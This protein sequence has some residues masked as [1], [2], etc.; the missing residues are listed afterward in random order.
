MFHCLFN[1]ITYEKPSQ[2]QLCDSVMYQDIFSDT[3]ETY[4]NNEF[5]IHRKSDFSKYEV[6]DEG[7]AALLNVYIWCDDMG[8]LHHP[9]LTTPAVIHV[10]SDTNVIKEYLYYQNDE[11]YIA[12]N[13]RQV[14][15]WN[16]FTRH[17]YHMFRKPFPGKFWDG[18]PNTLHNATTVP[19]TLYNPAKN[20][21]NAIINWFKHMV[22]NAVH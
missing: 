15:D 5:T 18:I 14:L 4:H 9:N 19:N 13:N 17:Y 12:P 10:Y 6:V 21:P 7:D 22:Q 3:L 16:T 20:V 1:S 8:R 2:Q 11:L